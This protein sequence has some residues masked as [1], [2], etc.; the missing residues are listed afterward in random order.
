MAHSARDTAFTASAR[1]QA[2]CWCM[3]GS[4]LCGQR[5]LSCHC[6]SSGSRTSC[7]RPDGDCMSRDWLRERAVAHA[8]SRGAPGVTGRSSCH[9]HRA[10]LRQL[11]REVQT[12]GERPID[13]VTYEGIHLQNDLRLWVKDGPLVRDVVHVERLGPP[14][15]SQAEPQVDEPVRWRS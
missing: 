12:R 8:F 13:E 14:I 6:W 1:T 10:R 7:T 15:P 11:V 3:Q 5:W 9:C 2:G 4:G